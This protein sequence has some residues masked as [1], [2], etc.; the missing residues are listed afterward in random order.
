MGF[1]SILRL[2][3]LVVALMAFS[4]PTDALAGESGA[5]E[6]AR[7]AADEGEYDRALTILEQAYMESSDPALLFERVLVLEKMGEQELALQLLETHE[8]DF[9]ASPD[10]EGVTL[11]RQRLVDGDSD[12]SA[13]ATVNGGG[14]TDTLGWGLTAG[15]LAVTGAGVATYISAGRQATKLRCSPASTADS[16]CEGVEAYGPMSPESYSSRAKR[17]RTLDA[18]GIG[19]MAMGAGL[20]AWG[21]VRL[22]SDS[23]AESQT[24]S[25]LVIVPALRGAAL[26]L[27]F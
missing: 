18:I 7:S 23:G 25:V 16:N 5:R 13:S 24:R 10:V 11:V 4:V 14:N 22:L 3:L 26:R 2:I 6:Q 17:V 20:S 19:A 21:L 27:E 8:A 15:G 9:R 1:S 12:A